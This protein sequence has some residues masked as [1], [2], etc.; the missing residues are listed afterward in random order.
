MRAKRKHPVL[1]VA[2]NL[3]SGYRTSLIGY[4]IIFT[5]IFIG[6]H[7]GLPINLSENWEA[8]HGIW[9]GAGL[10]PKI[11]LLVIGIMLTPISL[12]YF[13]SSGI[14]R[15]H[16]VGGAILFTML[17]SLISAVVMTVGFPVERLLT[18]WFGGQEI[19]VKPPL[20]QSG[21]EFFF[22]FLGYFAVGWMIG[23]SF[24][25]FNWQTGIAVSI[26]SLIPLIL[27]EL[28]GGTGP[29]EMFGYTMARPSISFIVEMLLILL[30]VG[31]V[32]ALNYGMHRTVAIKRK[33]I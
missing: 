8:G 26:L 19:L 1:I 18:D 29:I 7:L 4:W 33:L 6:I 17:L 2:D 13:I 22:S 11:Y 31:F 20:L 16:F 5:A 21:V 10:S 12:S 9:A 3:W 14:T 23:S 30:I 27:I 15:K 25:R 32:M 24:Y 28:I